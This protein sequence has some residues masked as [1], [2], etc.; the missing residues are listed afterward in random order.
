MYKMA[1]NFIVVA[2]VFIFASFN[3]C[4]MD[5][6]DIKWQSF[7]S[8]GRSISSGFNS[9]TY[10]YSFDNYSSDRVLLAYEYESGKDEHGF[11]KYT[12]NQRIIFQNGNYSFR[13]TYYDFF[14]ATPSLYCSVGTYDGRD[15]VIE[16]STGRI[17]FRD[18]E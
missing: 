1:L 2:L 12:S 9:W 11:T 13:L 15:L 18:K 5:D 16:R 14:A 6:S 10:E 17:V 7:I 8:T 4:K 3:G